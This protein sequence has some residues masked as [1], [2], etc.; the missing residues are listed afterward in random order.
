MTLPTDQ[1]TLP[2]K[3]KHSLYGQLRTPVGG[4]AHVSHDKEAK[5]SPT[6]TEAV[7]LNSNAHEV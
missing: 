4:A 5:L 7:F 1:R 2:R 6:G 3:E